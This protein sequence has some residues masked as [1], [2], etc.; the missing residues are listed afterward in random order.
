[1]TDAPERIW[2]NPDH[3][4]DRPPRRDAFRPDEYTGY[5]RDDI[6]ALREAAAQHGYT[7]TPKMGNKTARAKG[8]T[9]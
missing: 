4:I 5:V 3:W 6:E 2:A 1:M 7:L 9:Q 8:T